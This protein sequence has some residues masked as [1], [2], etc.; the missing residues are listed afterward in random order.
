MLNNMLGNDHCNMSKILKFINEKKRGRPRRAWR[1]NIQTEMEWRD[2]H[3]GDW[4]NRKLWKAG[5]GK[6]RQL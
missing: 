1:E 6:R 5:C 2:L 3:S 4:E